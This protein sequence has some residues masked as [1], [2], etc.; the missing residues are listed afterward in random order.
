MTFVKSDATERPYH[1]RLQALRSALDS[2][3]LAGLVV[4]D[5]VNIRYLTGFTGSAGVALVLPEECLLASDFRYTIQAHE[6]A[7]ESRFVELDGAFSAALP[8]LVADF[9]GRMGVEKDYLRV[10][11]WEKLGPALEGIDHSLVGGHVRKLRRLKAP[12][13]VQSIRE[14]SSLAVEV[15]KHLFDM[16]VV[17]RR[18]RDIALD[19]EVWGRRH[20]SDGVPFSYIV[21][22]GPNG[23]KPHAEPGDTV[24]GA[25]GL[26]VVDLGA[27]VDGY[28]SDMTR[29]FATGPVS[30]EESH[31]YAVALRAQEVG[32]EE[33][34]PGVSCRQVD[35]AARDVIEGEG[36]GDFFK[37]GLGH[38]VGLEV[39][40]EPT[41]SSRSDDV[42]E[43]GMVVT[44]EPGIYLEGVGGVRIE[45]S[46]VVT[47]AGIEVLTDMERRLETLTRGG[48]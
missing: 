38:G 40:E 2:D 18:E 6:Q 20:G 30:D 44:I 16:P 23:A 24:I 39:H 19:L 22:W 46:V 14:A 35:K 9:Q 48:G 3:G 21:A 7:H 32:R 28:A 41:V 29:T 25:Q 17:G 11:E 33:A 4:F 15:M 34:G 42:L 8:G 13:E 12:G 37:H 47:E 1:G 5:P 10:G 43:P 27:V 31:A 36:L 45:D 26:L